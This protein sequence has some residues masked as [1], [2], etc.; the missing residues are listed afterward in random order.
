MRQGPEPLLT[1]RSGR[2]NIQVQPYE[3]GE[4]FLFWGL[5]TDCRSWTVPEKGIDQ[6]LTIRSWKTGA[7]DQINSCGEGGIAVV[8]KKLRLFLGI[9]RIPTI[10]IH[11]CNNQLVDQG[12][13]HSGNLS[14]IL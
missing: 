3:V 9:G 7:E 2:C 1:H 5:C 8:I 6:I 14:K 4:A 13:S 11:R 12:I 10:L